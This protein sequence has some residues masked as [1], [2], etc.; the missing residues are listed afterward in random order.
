MKT[1]MKRFLLF[2]L[3]FVT[4][5]AS[6]ACGLFT[7]TTTTATTT[8]ES[9]TFDTIT[10][11][12]T[13][14][15]WWSQTVDLE[16][17]GDY[18][19]VYEL[20]EAL[21]L[22]GLVVESVNG[23][24]DKITLSSDAYT[25]DGFDSQQSGMQEITISYDLVSASFYVYVK[26]GVQ[27][28]FTLSVVP[29][30]KTEYLINDEI[31]TTGMEVRLVAEDE[32]YIIL[33]PDQYILSGYSMVENGTQTVTVTTL[34][35]QTSFEITVSG[36]IQLSEYYESAEGLTGDALKNQLHIIINTGFHGVTYG[37]ARYMLDET[38]RD[39]NN[40]SN[41]ILLYLGTS[42]SGEWDLGTTWNREHV[43]P[44]SLLGVPADNGTVNAASDLHN[45]KPANP[46]VNSS[47]GNKYF[48]DITTS[49]AYAPNRLEARGDIARILFYM[50]V[51][52]TI[53]HL[54]NTTPN[55]Y[56][57]GKLDTL[58]EWHE[59]DPVD[60]F[61]RNRNEVIYTKQ[62]NRN[63][64]IDYPHFVELIWD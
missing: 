64:F 47:R 43:W 4:I 35:L 10:E 23:L 19:T 28:G 50:E 37:D 5:T 38:D 6:T 45:L 51:M 14:G 1:I 61:E 59:L 25:V 62:H 46:S 56:E 54:V 2:T 16:L 44:Q 17:S 42:V 32:S 60:D 57:M 48:D 26:E 18:Q 20:D 55:T 24:G 8:S 7:S 22:E 27:S 36:S 12:I 33:T 3:L 9:T 53:Y 13:T 30:T 31:D 11:H 39:P 15:T 29:P 21:N 41:L 49:V 34:N 58:L 52:Y 63:P 40:S